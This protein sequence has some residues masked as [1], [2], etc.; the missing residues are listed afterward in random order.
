MGSQQTNT[1]YSAIYMG[2]QQTRDTNTTYSGINMGSQ[3]QRNTVV[4][5]VQVTG[6]QQQ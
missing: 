1:I 5:A 4:V 2:S 3:Q 6:E